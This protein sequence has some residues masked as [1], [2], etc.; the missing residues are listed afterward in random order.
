MQQWVILQSWSILEQYAAGAAGVAAGM[1]GVYGAIQEGLAGDGVGI[2]SI[3]MMA[4]V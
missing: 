3:G 2:A 1:S 4:G